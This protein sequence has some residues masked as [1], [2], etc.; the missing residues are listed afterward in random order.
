VFARKQHHRA[1]RVFGDGDGQVGLGGAAVEDQV[2]GDALGAGVAISE[3]S[4]TKSTKVT[5]KIATSW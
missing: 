5:K 1:V 4:T 3:R 2:D